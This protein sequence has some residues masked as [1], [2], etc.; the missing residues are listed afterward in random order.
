[1]LGSITSFPW[2][3][4]LFYGILA[5]NVPIF[6]SRRRMY[7]F[8]N[9]IVSFFFLTFLV[10]GWMTNNIA[11]VVFLTIIQFNGA[12]INVIIEALMVQQSRR[13]PKNGSAN[14]NSFSYLF[15]SIGGI[16]GAL[17]AAYMTQFMTPRISF[18]ICSLLGLL[19]A[20]LGITMNKEIE[21]SSVAVVQHRTFWQELKH[22]FGQLYEAIKIPQ[23]HRTIIYFFL[24][25]LLVPSFSDVNYYFQLNVV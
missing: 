8:I 19:I 23:I 11:I 21:G 13:D 1:M 10:P 18:A 25:G 17:L 4:K 16:V 14:L 9:G 6:G 7:I 5:D 15:V 12:F 3:I 22:N 2:C 20:F 24:C